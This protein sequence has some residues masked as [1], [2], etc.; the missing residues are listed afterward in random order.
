M[1]FH[2]DFLIHP[3]DNQ[4]NYSEKILLIG[5]C[6]TEHIGGSLKRL[7]FP[8][9]MNPNGILFDPLSITESLTDYINR[10]KF[11]EKDLN[12]REDIW[13]SWKHHGRFSG[14]DKSKLLYNINESIEE[15]HGFLKNA[16]WLILTFGT[17]YSYQLIG[18]NYLPVANCHKIPQSN[19]S[20]KLLSI[21]EIQTALDNCF[22]QLR[23]F[24]PDL[25]IILTVSPVRHIKDG[26]IENNRSKARL[27]EAAH[28]LEEKFSRIYYFPAYE[29][30]IDVLRDYRFFESDL[31]HP[32]QQAT[33]FVFNNFLNNFFDKETREI[34]TELE[35]IISSTEH[36][37]FHKDA[38]EYKRFIKNT[39]E[40]IDK[41]VARH[42]WLNF[43][44]EKEKLKLDE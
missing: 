8:V 10:K 18:E 19:F 12:R 37:P 7:K 32:N 26:I 38:Q 21:E 24:N 42:P 40:K 14:T 3:P 9:L 1:N 25:N 4:I 29:L 43:D 17:A 33:G 5:S 11:T 28:H 30:V 27:L 22:H 20:K 39:M 15:A 41:I 2:L 16:K 23:N 44:Q 6:F 35:K 36:K 34:A 31:V 13:F